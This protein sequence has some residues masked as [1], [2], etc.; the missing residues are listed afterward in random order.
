MPAYIMFTSLTLLFCVQATC[1]KRTSPKRRK[2]R[3][4]RLLAHFI[5][6]NI[7][8]AELL[9]LRQGVYLLNI[10]NTILKSFLFDYKN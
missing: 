6:I 7:K 1:G 10:F 9:M 4:E 2:Y 5:F 8:A 3:L